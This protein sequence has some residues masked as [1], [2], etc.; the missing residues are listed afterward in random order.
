MM[1]FKVCQLG[2]CSSRSH[3]TTKK[4]ILDQYHSLLASMAPARRNIH[5]LVSFYLELV[6]PSGR[7]SRAK[8]CIQVTS[9]EKGN[10]AKRL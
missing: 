9:S 2:P 1:H 6:I 10:K 7:P 8:V 3:H 4:V 5:G